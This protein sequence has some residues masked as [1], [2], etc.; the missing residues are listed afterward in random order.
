MENDMLS[1]SK[2][3]MK[4]FRKHLY[5]KRQ[6]QVNK[7][8]NSLLLEAELNAEAYSPRHVKGCQTVKCQNN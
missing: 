3:K 4:E 2:I 6:V 8:R 7:D 1:S 5:G